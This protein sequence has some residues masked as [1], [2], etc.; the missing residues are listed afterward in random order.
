MDTTKR[1]VLT[2]LSS[3]TKSLFPASCVLDNMAGMS[4]DGVN[5]NKIFNYPG[6][7]EKSHWGHGILTHKVITPVSLFIVPGLGPCSE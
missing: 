1:Q 2:L 4:L 3:S 7:K 5:K 6:R